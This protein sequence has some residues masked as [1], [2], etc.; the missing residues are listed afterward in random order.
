MSNYPMNETKSC[1]SCIYMRAGQRGWPECHRREPQISI[2]K[3]CDDE[4][5]NPITMWP[6]VSAT[7]WCGEYSPKKGG[8]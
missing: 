4:A 3:E 5:I 1:R 8:R 2:K 7:D 6:Y